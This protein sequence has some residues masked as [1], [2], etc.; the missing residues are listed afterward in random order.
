[1]RPPAPLA[2]LV[3]LAAGCA[4]GAPPAAP[5]AP[6]AGVLTGEVTYRPRI[7]LPPDA[8][9]HVRL[10]DV[11]RAD[12]PAKTVAEQTVPTEG[13]QVPV[14]FA[15]RYDPSQVRPRGRYAVRAE[16]RD[17]GGALRWT[18]DT[19]HPA[20]TQGAPTDGVTVRVVQVPAEA[21]GG[22]GG[23]AGTWR[24]VEIATPDG[25]AVR[26]DDGAALTVTFGDGGR[27]NGRTDCNAYAGTYEAGPGRALALSQTATTLAA[28]PGPSLAARYL[29]TLGR[30]ERYAVD[31]DR[32][33]LRARGGS[34][35]VFERDRAG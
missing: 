28:C 16:I 34:A 18:T 4:G 26:P 35:L 17:G 21:A 19:V 32:L 23:L 9:V 13:R 12:A 10:E 14:P 7:A 30:V 29:A 3:L 8:V 6:E 1:M 15:L 25:G 27:F 20:L 24:L 22:A 11:S 31:G 5:P 33:T 2:V